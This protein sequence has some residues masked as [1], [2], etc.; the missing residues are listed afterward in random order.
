[1]NNPF[2]EASGYSA[3]VPLNALGPASLLYVYAHTPSKGWWYQEAIITEP[4]GTVAQGPRLDV[5]VPTPLGTVHAASTFTIKGTAYDPAASPAQGIGVDRVSVYLN[6]DRKSGI[7]IGD[8]KLGYFDKFSSAV[9]PQFANA[10]WQ[11]TFQPSSWFDTSTMADNQVTPLTV[12][13]HSS[14]TG[15]EAEADTNMVISIP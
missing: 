9:S 8:A 14:V 15:Q 13:A 1:L 2:W 10:G 6:G 11:L 3:N 7:F 12:Y 4:V 5:E